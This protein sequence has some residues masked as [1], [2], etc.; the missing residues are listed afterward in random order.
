MPL[1]S[2]SFETGVSPADDASRTVLGEL[3][4]TLITQSGW[5]KVHAAE[6]LVWLGFPQQVK[7]IFLREQ[8]LYHNTPKHRVGVWRVLAQAEALPD[9]RK[10]WIGRIYAAFADPDCD[11]RIHA[12]EALAKLKLSP[13]SQYP[14]ATQGALCSGNRIFKICTMWAVAYASA[15]AF[16]NSRRA[17]LSIAVSDGDDNIR[18]ICSFAL[19][20]LGGLSP[21]EWDFLAFRA[22]SEPAGSGL[23]KSLLNTA[24]ATSKKEPV[25][26][27]RIAEVKEEMLRDYSIFS[28]EERNDLALSLA[29]RGDM[30]DLRVL[31]SFLDHEQVHGTDEPEAAMAAEVRS[32]AAFAILKIK[33]GHSNPGALSTDFMA[34]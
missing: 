14:E 16:D 21:A 32:S 13:L 27:G 33:A 23:R 22:L 15:E 4:N 9:Q 31:Q 34:K 12:A 28:G 24:F 6:Y 25:A 17:I 7:Q 30:T 8:E 29:E 18:K 2:G 10:G 11:D 3:E 1:D 20:Q 5:I 26:S 19:R